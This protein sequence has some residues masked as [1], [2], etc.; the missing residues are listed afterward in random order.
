MGWVEYER[1][2]VKNESEVFSSE[3]LERWTDLGIATGEQIWGEEPEFILGYVNFAHS[4]IFFP[5]FVVLKASI[6]LLRTISGF[7]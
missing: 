4:E 3:Q 6:C 5:V 7:P 2:R 1:K